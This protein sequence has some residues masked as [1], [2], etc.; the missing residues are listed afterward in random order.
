MNRKPTLLWVIALLFLGACSTK[1]E[2][3]PKDATPAKKD[4]AAAAEPTRVAEAGQANGTLT[5][6][7]QPVQLAYAYAVR[8]PG[9]FDKTT[10]DI[11]VIVTD[12]PVPA[13]VLEGL[14]KLDMD[15]DDCFN[16][17][18]LSIRGLPEI[19]VQGMYLRIDSEKRITSRSPHHHALENTSISMGGGEGGEFTIE[20]DSITGKSASDNPEFTHPWSYN[21]SFK[22]WLKKT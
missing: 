19:D 12:K 22:A 16:K 15:I 11:Q 21:V 6:S 17:V 1:T 13:E 18:A 14:R 9:S 4:S 2:P 5:V 20:E 7:G 8:V 3:A 10:Q